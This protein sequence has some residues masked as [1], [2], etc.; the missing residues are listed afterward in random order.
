MRLIDFV[1]TQ[2]PRRHTTISRDA[3]EQLAVVARLLERQHGRQIT[4]ADL[5]LPLLLDLVAWL[6]QQGRADRTIKGRMATLL[7]IWREAVRYKLAEPIPDSD[8]LPTVRCKRRPPRCWTIEEFALLVGTAAK[9]TGL[10]D[11]TDISRSVWWTALL[12][13]LYDSGARV[14]AALAIRWADVDLQR[15]CVSLDADNAKTGLGQSVTISPQTIVWLRR[16]QDAKQEMVWPMAF[17]RTTLW[18]HLQVMLEAC[19]LPVDRKSKFHRIRKTHA[20]YLAIG[21]SL[22]AAQRGLGHTSARMT[23]ESY[24]DPRLFRSVSA[25]D[26]IPRPDLGGAT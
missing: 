13:F 14:G 20:T 21:A 15:G 8:E 24:I 6:R 4:T 7:S 25:A 26:V 3:L 12:L 18:R 16:M 11:G 2:Y 1:R 9:Q 22:E 23:T 10:I 19:G 5:S 17:S